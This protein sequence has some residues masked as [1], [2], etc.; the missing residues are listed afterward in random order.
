MHLWIDL[1]E[2]VSYQVEIF[3]FFAFLKSYGTKCVF[4]LQALGGG[5]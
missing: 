2:P 4:P 3:N 5:T 1:I